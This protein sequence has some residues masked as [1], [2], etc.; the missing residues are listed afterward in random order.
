MAFTPEAGASPFAGYRLVRLR[1]RGGFATVWEATAPDGSLIALKFMSAHNS[2]ST[3]REL[4]ALRAFAAFSHPS[5]LPINQVWSIPGQIVIG[6]ELAEGSLLDLMMLYADEFQ[7][8][9]EVPRLLR[10]MG[11][12]ATA[13]DFL[14]A[15]R[16]QWD[17]RTVGFQHGDIKPNNV[18]LVGDQAKL[19]D[20][21]LA[22]PTLGPKTPCHRHG[23]LEYVAPEVIQGYAADTSDQF[24]LAVSYVL[25]RTTRFPFPAPPPPDQVGRGWVRPAPDL[26]HLTAAE[27]PVVARALSVI[28]Q[29]R[30]PTCMALVLALAKA[31]NASVEL[32]V[33]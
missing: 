15:R 6:M 14:N 4:R 23:T 7:K 24:S 31:L 17:G 11:E 30:F 10:Y 33:R 18:L 16:H 29:N 13:L 1:G 5:L 25:L 27:Q 26:S 9:I 28:P 20:Y 21:G 19:A 32:P 3:I 12:V 22:T 2:V 8:P